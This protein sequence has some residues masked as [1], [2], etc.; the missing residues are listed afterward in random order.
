LQGNGSIDASTGLFIAGSDRGHGLIE[1]TDMLDT[2][3][4]T[5]GA[6]LV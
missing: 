4:R 1:A 5:V 2:L 3:T 6:S